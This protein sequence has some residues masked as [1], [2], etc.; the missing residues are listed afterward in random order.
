MSSRRA[1]LERLTKRGLLLVVNGA[2]IDA[3]ANVHGVEP[4][5]PG[6][7]VLPG[8]VAGCQGVAGSVPGCRVPGCCRVLPGAAG[9]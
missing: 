6:C 1:Q 5:L 2:P 3:A 9:L 8:R 4:W 7:R